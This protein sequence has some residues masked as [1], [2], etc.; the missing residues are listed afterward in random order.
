MTETPATLILSDGTVFTGEAFGAIGETFGNAV[1]DTGMGAYQ[2]MLTDPAHHGHI[3]VATAPQTG[4]TGW[5]DEDAGN[6]R[7]LVWAAGYVVR[8]PSPRPSN[9][10]SQRSLDEVLTAQGVVG[11][12]GIDTRALTS[13]LRRGGIMRAAISSLPT[14]PAELL[15]KLKASTG[16]VDAVADVTTPAPYTVD[17]QG[18]SHHTIVA[19]DYGLTTGVTNEMAAR[20]VTVK[21]VPASAQL[22]DVTAFK[23]DGVLIAGG[24]GDPAAVDTT[25]TKQLLDAGVPIF[26]I[27]L[28]AQVLAR[29][30][31]L[32]TSALPAGHHG[33]NQPVRRLADGKIAI[34]AHNHD[35]TIDAPPP[36]PVQVTHVAVNDATIEGIALVKGGVTAAF[37]VSFNP[38]AGPHD[39]ETLFDEF[40]HMMQT[41]KTHA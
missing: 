12:K 32:S 7:G 21:V 15:A 30:L 4:N 11:I 5:N 38:A 23:P 3:V 2:E 10:R 25:L 27:G 6:P 36:G 20:G 16:P 14:T 13:H 18:P 19:L 8:D 1:F 24:P 29:A 39:T 28:G 17:A 41:E 33:V 34:T 35:Y 9:W 37:G 31:G 40:V 26:G 22:A